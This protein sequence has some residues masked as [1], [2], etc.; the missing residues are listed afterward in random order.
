MKKSAEQGSHNELI[1]KDGIYKKL[2]D[3]TVS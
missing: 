3:I 2:Y 1:E